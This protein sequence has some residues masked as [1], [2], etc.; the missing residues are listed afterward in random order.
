MRATVAAQE[1]GEGAQDEVSANG[2]VGDGTLDG[3]KRG[4]GKTERRGAKGKGGLKGRDKERDEEEEE[5]RIER[6]DED[7][8]GSDGELGGG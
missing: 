5:R 1:N 3:R 7:C 6:G 8:E 4:K 2:K